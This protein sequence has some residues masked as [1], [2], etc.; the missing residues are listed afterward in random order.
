VRALVPQ[1]T[2]VVLGIIFRMMRSFKVCLLITEVFLVDPRREEAESAPEGWKNHLQKNMMTAG[3]THE[4]DELPDLPDYTNIEQMGDGADSIIYSAEDKAIKKTTIIRN[5]QRSDDNVESQ[6]A[7]FSQIRLQCDKTQEMH[8]VF[9]KRELMNDPKFKTGVKHIAQCKDAF[10]W[11]PGDTEMYNIYEW[12]AMAEKWAAKPGS[13][14]HVDIIEV[15]EWAGKEGSKVLEE[16]TTSKEALGLVKQVMLALDAMQSVNIVYIHHDLKWANVAVDEAKCLRLI[17]MDHYTMEHYIDG[18]YG[19][20]KKKFGAEDALYAPVERRLYN[21]WCGDHE[22]SI[23]NHSM[24]ES[25]D[26]NE[27]PCPAAYTFDIFSAG[28]MAAQACALDWFFY[29]IVFL[30]ANSNDGA[31][32]PEVEKHRDAISQ[33][34]RS[35]IP[36]LGLVYL[37]MR[38]GPFIDFKVELPEP[39]YDAA[40][41]V[42]KNQLINNWEKAPSIVDEELQQFGPD[43]I[44]LAISFATQ[45]ESNTI[46]TEIAKNAAQRLGECKK[47]PDKVKFIESMMHKLPDKRPTAAATLTSPLFRGVEGKCA[48]DS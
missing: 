25:M 10:G 7:R 37:R 18:D 21:F 35:S 46:L 32:R 16:L 23:H 44:K 48:F 29:A 13:Q 47:D 30:K 14:T 3:D 20:S 41:H 34:L 33:D 39:M 19:T 28:I 26:E 43:Q 4:N 40:Q 5:P 27:L 2:H 45:S 11:I 6:F 31:L 12:A 8:R 42:V 22:H 15:Y 24:D 17:D 36:Q 38:L 9:R 1:N